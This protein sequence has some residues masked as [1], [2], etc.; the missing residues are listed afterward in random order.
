MEDL[1][2]KKLYEMD[3]LRSFAFLAVVL[4]H[5]LGAYVRRSDKVI[6]L[7]EQKAIIFM[8][9]NIRFAVP[10]FVFLFGFFLLY[11]PKGKFNYFK[12]LKSRTIQ[13]LVPYIFVSIIYVFYDFK[14]RDI[15]TTFEVFFKKLIFGQ[16]EYH[17]WYVFMIFQ[18]V[19]LAPLFI[20]LFSWINS[21]VKKTWQLWIVVFIYIIVCLF[22]LKLSGLINQTAA[23]QTVFVRRRNNFFMPWMIFFGMGCIIGSNYNY[24][25]LIISKALPISIVVYIFSIVYAYKRSVSFMLKD[26]TVSFYIN[27]FLS[28]KYSLVILVNI[29][30][31]IGLAVIISK[32]DIISKLGAFIS[33]HSYGAY[34]IH[35]LVMNRISFNLVRY[36]PDLD[37]KIFYILL[38]VGA[39]ALSVLFAFFI[40]KIYKIVS[41]K[42]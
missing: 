15:E 1:K 16:A 39:A 19:I 23:L 9:E 42:S 22:Y 26:N 41:V 34:L 36:C 38:F 6:S 24:F 37:L 7:N 13:L 25:K 12:Y 30:M 31:L 21:K 18:F 10:L 2:S 40:D 29:F 28:P 8:F 35:V 17:L 3:I 4:Q 11:S 20:N 5:V 32:S 14:V 33:R 27:D